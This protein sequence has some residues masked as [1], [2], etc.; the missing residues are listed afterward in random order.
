MDF[1]NVG[2]AMASV[3]ALNDVAGASVVGRKVVSEARI[4]EDGNTSAAS[5]VGRSVLLVVS[6]LAMVGMVMV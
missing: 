5:A 3:D 2:P 1:F 4:G 6:V